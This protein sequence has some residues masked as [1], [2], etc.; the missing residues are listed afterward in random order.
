MKISLRWL[1]E[2]IDLPAED[3]VELAGVLAMLGHEVEG[4]EVLEAEWS[5]VYVGKVL[6]ISA[7]PDADKIR[8][9]Q[10]DSG[11]GAEQIICGAWNFDE[12]ATVAVARPGAVLPGDFEI[13]VREI[14]GVTSNGMI[15]SEKELGL[16][17]EH[18]GILVLDGD[19]AIGA[20]FGDLV[21]L[22]DVV[23]DLTITP[24]RPDAMSVHGIARDLAAHYG[25]EVRLPLIKEIVT[26]GE[27]VTTVS[28]EDPD[29]C[30]R[31]VAR[32]IDDVV[33]GKSP[34][35]MRHRLQK[36]GI[37]S[38]SNV[39]D[40]TNY[41]MVE[42][43]QPLHAFDADSIAGDRLT[44]KRARD[45]ET[46][47]TLDDV[48]RKL[49]A[50]DLIIY[51]DEGPTSMS[52]TMGG[53]R[54]EVS[55]ETTRVLME[56]ASW[57]PST[58]MYMSRRHGL[59]SEAS[60]RFERGVDPLLADFADQ[61]AAHLVAGLA[62]GSV[63]SAHIDEMPRPIV[64]LELDLTLG[65][66]E[67]LLGPG[68]DSE[69]VTGILTG[70]GMEASGSDPIHVVVPTF[71]PDIDRSVD[72]VEE[73]ARIHGFEKFGSTIPVGSHGGY[74][75]E[76]RRLRQLHSA[77]VGAGLSQAITLPLV[78][79][80]AISNF[81]WHTDDLVVVT[82]PLREEE[83]R[84][85]NVM[86]PSLV[87]SL[88]YNLSHGLD[89]AALF[90]TGRVFSNRPSDIDE[91]LPLEEDRLCIAMTGTFGVAGIAFEPVTVDG[92]VAFGLIRHIGDLLG[93]ESL[94]L[95]PGARP[96]LHPG[97]T[98][99]VILGD[100][101][102][103]FAGE[104]LPSVAERYDIRKRVAVIEVALAPLLEPPTPS[105]VRPPS[106]FPHSDFDLSF[107]VPT[108]LAAAE[109]LNA[110][111]DAGGQIV[112]SAR[113]FDEF[114]GVGDGKKALAV[115]YRLRSDEGTLSGEQVGTVRESMIA[116]AGAI[117]AVLRGAE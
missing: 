12:G 66:V 53:A 40:V 97:R 84:L 4:Y 59:R 68:F 61:R 109:L 27:P 72:L 15:C 44:I 90:E 36:A 55:A 85:R 101:V 32:Q 57:D 88:S 115:R 95:R 56:A 37:R 52:G 28:I 13:G 107:V 82:N 46:L 65:H 96:G 34:L 99:D 70:L 80:E 42:L 83:G 33:V 41:V 106:T 111:R 62:G 116:A 76:Q 2:F 48:E 45:D 63:L 50:D 31:F 5:E 26:E 29:G 86:T 103:G 51:D 112:E 1:Q 64:P 69:Q 19:L 10:V 105:M 92:A 30:R 9:C 35:W 77:L 11:N 73:V 104:L 93:I 54:S 6:E 100:R 39:V 102:I 114:T 21:E 117:G 14:R 47:V 78:S 75:A 58:I 49:S 98:A 89:S 94:V 3:P 18:D 20:L 17:Q 79:E 25:L 7:H 38:I 87:H 43:G 113:V 16:G 110:T 74:T 23:F 22:P 8:V 91:R 81:G 24:N 71:R 67:R 108:T 60:T